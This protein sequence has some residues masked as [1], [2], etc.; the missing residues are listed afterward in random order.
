MAMAVFST[1]RV[2]AGSRLPPGVST[3]S[4]VR[5]RGGPGL[6]AQGDAHL[7]SF[8]GQGCR[9]RRWRT[10]GR[11]SAASSRRSGRACC[12]WPARRLSLRSGQVG[13][14]LLGGGHDEF[15]RPGVKAED[16]VAAVTPR[17]GSGSRRQRPPAWTSAVSPRVPRRRTPYPVVENRECN[18]RGK[19]VDNVLFS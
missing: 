15:S 7:I 12:G 16:A 17:E 1:W 19:S 10:T 14:D 8:G 2:R 11:H 13:A 4:H 5:R 6:R 3:W 18:K 9:R